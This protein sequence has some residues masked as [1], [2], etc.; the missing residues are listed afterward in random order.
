MDKF[1]NVLKL[2][3]KL[4]KLIFNLIY[5]NEFIYF[6][7]SSCIYRPLKL[8]PKFIS[9]SNNVFIN[10]FARIEGVSRYNK[11]IYFPKIIFNEGVSVQQGLHLTCANSI[12]IGKD[13]AIAA[14][15]TI[16]DLNHRYIDINIAPE[17]QDI[18]VDEVIIGENCKIYNNAVILP[19]VFLGK[20]NIVAANSVVRK[21][22][23]E[24]FIVLAGNP[25]KIV[26]KYNFSLNRWEKVER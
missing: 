23:Y 1:R 18:E 13:T 8:T 2:K 17:Y 12:I 5:K 21:G 24:D 7:S 6:G 26:K 16:T 11:N 25:A 10:D 4:S 14:Y 19:G 20:H 22:V 9:I 3:I 15:V